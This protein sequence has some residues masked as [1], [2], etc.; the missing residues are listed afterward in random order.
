MFLE[1]QC[2]QCYD[3]HIEITKNVWYF[4]LKSAPNQVY[5]RGLLEKDSDYDVSL[6]KYLTTRHL[7]YTKIC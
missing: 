4:V 3:N 7:Y 1:S 5:C 2:V 6:V